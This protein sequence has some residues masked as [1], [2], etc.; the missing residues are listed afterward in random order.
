MRLA[1][2]LL[3]M[4]TSG[5]SSLQPPPAEDQPAP[6]E[7]RLGPGDK[8]RVNVW[9]EKELHQDLELGPDGSAAFPLIG[10]V[11]MAGLTLDETRVELAKLLKAEYV[12]PVVSVALLEMRSHVIHVLGE[13]ARPGSVPYVRGATALGAILAA[14]GPLT[15]TADLSQVHVV[16]TRLSKPAAYGLDLEALLAGESFDMWLLPGDTVYVPT[17]LLTRWNRWWR[18]AWPWS[19]P[20][21]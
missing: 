2:L 1:F 9:G 14:G 17:R 16:R 19:D 3:L 6:F 13:V 21:D 20:V 4:C 5:C 7:F 8:I 12:N 18:Q 15:A 10:D 11:A